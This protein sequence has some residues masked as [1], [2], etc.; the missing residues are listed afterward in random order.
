MGKT[1]LLR[2]AIQV[3]LGDGIDG[4]RILYVAFDELP[5]L[6]GIK[7]PVLAICRWFEHEILKG[8]SNASANSGRP[9]IGRAHV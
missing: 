8:S 3:L 9:E 2:Q 7:E 4:R 5:S 1:I 6:R